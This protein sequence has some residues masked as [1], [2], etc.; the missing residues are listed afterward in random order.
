M[1]PRV[2]RIREAEI[3]AQGSAIARS[4]DRQDAASGRG[5]GDLARDATYG[6]SYREGWL[7]PLGRLLSGRRP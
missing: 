1:A 2:E 6:Q 7:A 3:K 5:M 4:Q